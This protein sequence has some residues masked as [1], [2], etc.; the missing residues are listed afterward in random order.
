MEIVAPDVDCQKLN[1]HALLSRVSCDDAGTS[2]LVMLYIVAKYSVSFAFCLK[3]AFSAFNV[4]IISYNFMF[5]IRVSSSAF[6]RSSA[7]N[8]QYFSG[9]RSKIISNQSPFIKNKS[10]HQNL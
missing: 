2:S 8:S 10:F 5:S 9:A 4:S 6:R 3:A 7:T 1:G